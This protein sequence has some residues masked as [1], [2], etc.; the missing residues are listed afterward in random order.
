M[1][2]RAQMFLANII[3]GVVVLMPVVAQASP[4]FE[5]VTAV[6]TV[7]Q[8][9]A[10]Q[11][12]TPEASAASAQRWHNCYRVEYAGS[13]NYPKKVYLKCEDHKTVTI[14]GPFKK[15]RTYWKR[16]PSFILAVKFSKGRVLTV[17]YDKIGQ[18]LCAHDVRRD[19]DRS[20]SSSKKGCGMY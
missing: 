13:K 2:R 3:A 7:G 17:Y 1:N 9:A 14:K 6:S 16:M 11:A 8:V 4:K 19:L 10:D 15:G 12:F 20:P 5:P 18:E